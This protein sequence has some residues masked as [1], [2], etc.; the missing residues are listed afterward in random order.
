[1]IEHF[2]E[3]GKVKSSEFLAPTARSFRDGEAL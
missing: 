2:K 3:V 1:L